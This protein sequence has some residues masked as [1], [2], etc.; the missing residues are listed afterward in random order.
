[1][2][3]PTTDWWFLSRAPRRPLSLS[4]PPPRHS[5]EKDI[6]HVYR[7]KQC[8]PPLSA[9]SQRT[10]DF[11]SLSFCFRPAFRFCCFAGTTCCWEGCVVCASWETLG[12]S[13]WV[14]FQGGPILAVSPPLHGED[15]RGRGKMELALCIPLGVWIETISSWKERTT[16]LQGVRRDM[17]SHAFSRG[18]NW[19]WG[20]RALWNKPE[21]LYAVSYYVVL[22]IRRTNAAGPTEI[23]KVLFKPIHIPLHSDSLV[24]STKIGAWESIGQAAVESRGDATQQ[25]SPAQNVCAAARRRQT[26]RA[27]RSHKTQQ[28]CCLCKQDLGRAACEWPPCHP[29][30]CSRRLRLVLQAL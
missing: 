8:N 28:R 13:Y 25:Q 15:L 5:L 7:Y 14:G 27:A 9:R 29:V 12:H 21:E 24:D 6:F 1:M 2:N 19:R 17:A 22:L 20:A 26:I 16:S 4:S 10:L 3:K 30:L 11:Y 18:S 23:K